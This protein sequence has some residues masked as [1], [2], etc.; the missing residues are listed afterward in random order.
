METKAEKLRKLRAKRAEMNVLARAQQLT[1][2]IQVTLEEEAD[3]ESVPEPTKPRKL[4]D[5]YRT[6]N[7]Y[8]RRSQSKIDIRNQSVQTDPGALAEEIQ[9]K[10]TS[11]RSTLSKFR[12]AVRRHSELK[13][14]HR[15]V[16][17]PQK[18]E[19]FSH[20]DLAIEKPKFEEREEKFQ[21][22]EMLGEKREKV[23]KSDQFNEYFFSASKFM[24]KVLKRGKKEENR[25]PSDPHLKQEITI[26]RPA[27]IGNSIVNTLSWSELVPEVFL[28]VYV[29]KNDDG[30]VFG[31]KDKIYIWNTSFT[32]RPEF[33]LVSPI[34]VETALFSPFS[35]EMVISGCQSGKLCIYDLREKKEPVRKS[36]PSNE[37]HRS[38]ITGLEFVGGRN[39]NNLISISEEG[40]LCV[41]SLQDLEKPIRKIDLHPIAENKKT[42]DK[43]DFLIEPFSISSIPGDTTSG[44]YIGG[45]DGNIYQCAVLSS[46]TNYHSA[47]IYTNVFRGHKSIVN[48]LHH[49][50]SNSSHSQLS[51]LMLSGSFDWSVKL[52]HPRDKSLLYDFKCFQDPVTDVHW[53]PN[54]PAM[55]VS[56]DASGNVRIFNLFKDF[57]QPVYQTKISDCVFNTKWDHS[58]ENLAITDSE[59]RVHV[60]KFKPEFFEHRQADLKNFE[61]SI[62]H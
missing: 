15:I 54:H 46:T 33:E 40:R 47:K 9:R 39:S 3:P 26:E 49:Q 6:G 32:E 22:M 62:R 57:D 51:G 44:V 28:S 59:G 12:M 43:F 30:A 31:D 50:K 5:T 60:K 45:V 4:F 24:E 11:V 20:V 37:S 7:Y 8:S 52:W 38:S 36:M 17:R 10:R 34:K 56:G 19:S 14:T 25:I 41:W 21:I 58:G 16:N 1:K 55:F 61:M 53:C 18:R 13:N 27:N 2:K 29:P 48:C 23:L 42:E 35:S